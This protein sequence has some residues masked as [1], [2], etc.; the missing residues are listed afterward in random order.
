[1]TGLDRPLRVLV[2][3]ET[4]SVGGCDRFLADLAQRL[5]PSQV[6]LTF[7]GNPHPELDE[8]LAARVPGFAGRDIVPVANMRE[9]LLG[10]A[11][12]RLGISRRARAAVAGPGDEMPVQ[13]GS[14]SAASAVEDTVTATQRMAQG[15]RNVRLLRALIRRHRPDVLHANNGGYPGAESVRIAPLA[16]RREGVPSVQFVHNM[17]Y[18]IA[19]PRSLERSLDGRV[20]RAVHRWIT[21]AH[22]ASD[23]LAEVRSIPRERVATVH[24]GVPLPPPEPDLGSARTEMGFPPDAVGVLVVAAFEP[25]KGHG[26]LI[27]AVARSGAAGDPLHVALVG[28]GPER[29]AAEE[30]VRALGLG[31][32]FRFLGWRNDV[33]RL[34]AAS[35]LLALPSLAHECLPYAILEAMSHGKPV[36]STDIAGIPEMVVDDVTGLVVA[37]GDVEGLAGALQ[38]LASNPEEGRRQGSAGRDRVA[39]HFGLDGMTAAVVT[40]WRAAAQTARG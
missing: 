26:V 3:T 25:R 13:S 16:A 35:D 4:Y 40:H 31:D 6:E 39:R 29:E 30:R 36:V 2:L 24:Y 8:Y 11:A 28:V 37:P 5:D 23:A 21:A 1:M 14:R 34:L 27:D 20:D 17:P 9:P 19:A 22:R 15:V 7:A 10:R 33:D 32:R 18:P 12:M 38:R